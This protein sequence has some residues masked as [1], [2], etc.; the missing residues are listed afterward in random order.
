[1]A[2]P[3]DTVRVEHPAVPRDT[4]AHSPQDLLG[5]F[6][7]QR[8]SGE[9][10]VIVITT[11]LYTAEITS[12]G[13]LIRKWELSGYKSWDG[14]PVQLVDFDKGGDFSLLFT[15]GD[16]KL[17]NTRNLY[18]DIREQSWTTYRLSGDQ[19][20]ILDLSLP[21]SDGRRLTKRMTVHLPAGTCQSSEPS[22]FSLAVRS[23]IRSGAMAAPAAAAG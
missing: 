15:S 12:K 14:H 1:M 18:F 13:G 19:S 16:G 22:G 6:F 17:I 8:G 9:E 3:K 23:S 7:A 5:S 20:L 2:L 21:V 11:D 10:K 4:V